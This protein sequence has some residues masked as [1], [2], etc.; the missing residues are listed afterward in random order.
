MRVITA[1]IFIDMSI[2]FMLRNKVK[3]RN[4]QYF[5]H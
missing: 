2:I 3:D 5:I 4:I 1:L